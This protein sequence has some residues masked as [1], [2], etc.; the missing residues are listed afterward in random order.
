MSIPTMFFV[1][2]EGRVV[3]RLVGFAPGRVEKSL[4]KLLG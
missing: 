1:D 4:R 3:E 2:R